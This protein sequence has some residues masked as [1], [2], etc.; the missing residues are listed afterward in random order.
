MSEFSDALSLAWTTSARVFG[1]TILFGVSA[2]A[3]ECVIHDM[4]YSTEV[5]NNRPG[6]V[7]VLS[8]SV[9]M[10]ASDWT[11]AAG[12]KGIICTVGGASARVLNDPDVGY[13]ADTVTLV[14]GP[15]T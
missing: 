8:G 4:A 2:T 13:T 15:R 14:L 9:V 5:E 11:A 1:E 10:K 7:A 12:Q 6:R 3:Y